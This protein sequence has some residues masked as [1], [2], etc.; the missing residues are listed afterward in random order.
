MGAQS[1]GSGAPAVAIR[2]ADRRLL[3]RLFLKPELAVGEAYMDGS[4]EV[5]NGDIYDLLDLCLANLG[6]R[7]AH[8]IWRARVAL[9]G[10]ARNLLHCNPAFASR[11]NAAHHYDFP[12]ALY[13]SFLDADRQYS[14]AYFMS[15]NDT[16]EQAQERKKNHLAAKLVLRPGQNVLDI[17]CGWGGLAM[18][19]ARLADVEVTG[20]T[21][22]AEQ[23]GYANARARNAGLSDR[24]RFLFQ[25]YRD[26]KGRYDRIVSVGM[27]EHVGRKDQREYFRKIRELLNEDGMALVHTI[28]SASGPIAGSPWI[29]KYIFPGGHIPALSEIVPAIE[30]AGL[31]I[32]DIEVLRLH[33]A[34]TLNAWRRR[35]NESRARVATLHDERFCRMWEFYLASCEAGFRHSGLVN[36]Q[37]QVTRRIDAAPLTRDYMYDWRAARSR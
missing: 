15:M 36:F 24:V 17:G 10:L 1:F 25:D 31:Y 29:Q 2:V 20:V 34:E 8:W 30:Q 26:E 18:H 5:E 14:C 21:L 3:W 13:E 11:A 22:S 19:L 16:L 37:I 28:G 23:L 4:L 33:Y 12:H 27:F 7:Y 32:T 35:F 9:R 6:W